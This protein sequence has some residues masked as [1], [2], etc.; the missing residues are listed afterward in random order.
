MTDIAKALE[1]SV[2]ADVAAYYAGQPKRNPNPATLAELPENSP[3][4][5]KPSITNASPVARTIGRSPGIGGNPSEQ[6]ASAA[7]P[8]RDL[9][10]CG[11]GKNGQQ[12]RH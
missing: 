1:E 10:R 7:Q 3:K 8:T 6:P 9:K 12:R 4:P 11:D 5:P 2:I